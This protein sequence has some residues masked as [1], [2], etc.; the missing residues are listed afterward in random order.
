MCWQFWDALAQGSDPS[1]PSTFTVESAHTSHIFHIQLDHTQDDMVVD[2]Q[3]R[4][5][6]APLLDIKHYSPCVSD[7]QPSYPT[8]KH[9]DH[10]CHHVHSLQYLCRYD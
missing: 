6:E 3:L 9:D 5:H 7:V 10:P 8:E 4:T 2:E 1:N